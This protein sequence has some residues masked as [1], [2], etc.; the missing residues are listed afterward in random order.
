MIFFKKYLSIDGF[1]L[2]YTI[3][4][5]RSLH[6]RLHRI[7]SSDAT[8]LFH[9]HPF[10]YISF[11]YRGSYIDCQLDGDKITRKLH[12]A[13]SI[14]IST[15][16]RL[17][18]LEDV[19][20]DTR[21]LFCT[22]GNYKWHAVSMSP[23]TSTDGIHRR[24]VKGVELYCKRHLGVWFIGHEDLVEASEETRHSIFQE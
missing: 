8:R 24:D 20:P 14:V 9:S 11:L 17:H 7:L 6:I 3:L 19:K 23:D 18:R 10:H 21:T 13:P 16:N 5:I 12:T 1:L 4:K 2:R 15:S 22:L